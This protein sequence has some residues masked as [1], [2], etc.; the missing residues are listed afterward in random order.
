MMMKSSDLQSF[1]PKDNVGLNLGKTAIYV[2]PHIS[3]EVS[4][5]EKAY[6]YLV[7]TS[8]RLNPPMWAPKSDCNLSAT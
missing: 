1:V 7:L 3:E 4:N 8:Q 5:N 2:Y 6:S